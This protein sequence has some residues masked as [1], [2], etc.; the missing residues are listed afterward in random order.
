[1]SNATINDI[2]KAAGV[3]KATV[4]RVLNNSMAVIPETKKNVLDIMKEKNY[5]PSATARNLSKRTSD[6]I[7]VVVPEVDNPFFGGILRAVTDRIEKDNLTLICCNTDDNMEKDFRAL[8][9]L[10]E[11]RVRGLLYTP[12]VEYN[13]DKERT[14]LAELLKGM[15]TPVV[16]LDRRVGLTGFDGV[17][18]DDYQGMYDATKALV[19]AGHS[20]IAIINASLERDLARVRYNGY[21]AAMLDS[22]IQPEERY[23]F[24]GT[25]RL[26]R[27]YEVS[28]ELLAMEDRPTAVITC[29]NWTTLGFYKALC[30]RKETVPEDIICIGLDRIEEFEI[31]GY[32]MNFIERDAKKMGTRAIE[33]L[34]E[35]M[36][37]PDKE[38]GDFILEARLH[39]YHV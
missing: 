32:K 11:Q 9:M 23:H 10:K 21:R 19:N 39:M 13:T 36:E 24:N 1:M 6:M 5:V 4:S 28:K 27:T 3:S 33:L 37:H 25:Y 16:F 22:G 38:T 29:S 8:E 12:A 20:K 2:A 15:E 26:T 14:Y 17:Y 34:I 30:E 31:L 7:G 18:F 35:R